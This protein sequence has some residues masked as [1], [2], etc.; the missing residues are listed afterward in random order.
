MTTNTLVYD[1]EQFVAWCP[2][3]GFVVGT[4]P[5]KN[6]TALTHYSCGCFFLPDLTYDEVIEQIK[7][8]RHARWWKSI[9]IGNY[10]I[11]LVR[12]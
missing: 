12:Y 3:H 7:K 1:A 8:I 10:R 11:N 2:R 5:P 4:R 6:V 9:R